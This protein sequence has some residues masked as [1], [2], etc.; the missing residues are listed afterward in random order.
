LSLSRHGSSE[1]LDPTPLGLAARQTHLSISLA[2]SSTLSLAMCH[3]YFGM[4]L[5][6]G[7][8]QLPWV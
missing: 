5:T 2:T 4:S 1:L 7:Y 3:A 8:T 6:Y